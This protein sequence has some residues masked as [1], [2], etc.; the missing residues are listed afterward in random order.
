[1]YFLIDMCRRKKA[2]FWRLIEVDEMG[3][4]FKGV[5]RLIKIQLALV[6][7]SIL[8]HLQV[9]ASHQRIPFARLDR[10]P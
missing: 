2:A 1:M 6:S 5:F 3:S 7:R 10:H 4:V 8:S 9:T